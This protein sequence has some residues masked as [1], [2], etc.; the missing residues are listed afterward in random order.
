MNSGNGNSADGRSQF[1]VNEAYL[2]AIDF[3]RAGH[4]QDADL[5]CTSIIQI[6]PNHINAINL[7]GLI[8]QSINRHDFAVEQFKG[9][10]AINSNLALLHFN[11]GIS[12]FKLGYTEKAV[13]SLDLALQNEPE[14]CQITD[15]LSAIRNG[16]ATHVEVGAISLLS[17]DAFWEGAIIHKKGD[18]RGAISKYNKSLELQP[19][20]SSALL[21]LGLALTDLDRFDEAVDIFKELV[22]RRPDYPEA[23]N[24][25][26][27]AFK[28]QGNHALAVDSFRRAISLNPSLI[29]VYNNL[30]LAL[31]EQGK[32]DE[33]LENLENALKLNPNYGKTHSNLALVYKAQGRNDKALDSLFNVISINPDDFETYYNLGVIQKEQGLVAEATASY[34]KAINI[35]PDFSLA[36][37]N[38]GNI[39]FE[40]KKYE[41]A[42]ESY[43]KA[44]TF[45]KGDVEAY[46]NLGATLKELGKLDEAVV[47]CQKAI[48]LDPNFTNAHNNL[49]TILQK[50]GKIDESIISYQKA[51]AI[52]PE[53]AKYYSNLGA[54]Y[55]ENKRYD[56]AILNLQKSISIDPDYGFAHSALGNVYNNLGRYDEAIV[57]FRK[58]LSISPDLIE[59]HNSLVFSL[60]LVSGVGTDVCIKERK[61]WAKIHA[62]P[63]QDH[64]LYCNNSPDPERTLRIGYVGADFR[65]HSAAFIFSPMIFKFDKVNFEVFCYIGNSKQDD[66][67]EKF[68]E[69]S[70]G[71]LEIPYMDD[72]SLAT[73][74]NK[75]GIDILVDLAGHTCGNRLLTFARKPAPIQITAW[76]YPKGTSMNA[77]DY[78]FADP[79]FIPFSDR[80]NYKEKIVDLPCMVHLNPPIEY[81][82]VNE[83]PA[84]RNG[85]ITFG[86]FNRIE[87]NNL[88]L[89]SLWAEILKRTPNAKLLIKSGGLDSTLRVQELQVLFEK[90]GVSENRLI[91][92][93]K[94]NHLVQL[95][96][97][98]YIDIMLD[99]FPHNGGITTLESLRMGIPVLTCETSSVNSVSAS[100]LH[101][102]GLEEWRAKSEEDFVCR[103]VQ[104]AK[105]FDKLKTLREQLRN[106]FD[107]SFVGDSQLFV[108]HI[109][110]VYRKIWR[111]WCKSKRKAV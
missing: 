52:K 15:Y 39:L 34:K 14:N 76:G 44:I 42:V 50:Q 21:N 79:I 64:W 90:M 10:I 69:K 5:L 80:C 26:G 88:S 89:Y 100:I 72:E 95:E 53:D 103:A 30:G 81:P 48:M 77:I 101:L 23:H 9:A 11:L 1:T 109:E 99:T 28:E 110:L 59:A 62:E 70:T 2:K 92:M 49:G 65:R 22:V 108:D 86:A 74:I 67:T 87:K 27:N 94:S 24:N 104:F 35:K 7:I 61:N 60:D 83:L 13:K 68:K 78:I 16:S 55:N 91:L 37:L 73:A 96:T 46:S 111:N 105:E 106:R 84:I 75:D 54:A 51:I 41:D 57:C 4:F 93:G 12:L 82:D 58:A 6:I 102:L 97:H 29:D 98:N 47:I 38:L 45:N 66:Y 25:L 17:D 31:I 107:S 36:H 56:K 3:Y 32:Y 19:G 8:A 43:Q 71:W 63:L 40:A 20:K 33:A 18:L 85:Y